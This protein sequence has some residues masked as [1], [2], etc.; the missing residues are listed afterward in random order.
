LTEN[1]LVTL[2]R[3]L[4]GVILT[5]GNLAHQ[6]LGQ[7]LIMNTNEVAMA[8]AAAVIDATTGQ[9]NAAAQIA[10]RTAAPALAARIMLNKQERRV[11][12]KLELLADRERALAR[13]R[14][15]LRR[16]RRKLGEDKA[17]ATV[18]GGG[19]PAGSESGTPAVSP[20]LPPAPATPTPAAPPAAR[21]VAGAR[22]KG[23]ATAKRPAG[24]KRRSRKATKKR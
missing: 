4:G 18:P 20:A 13:R 24:A 23:P 1:P 10:L 5:Q 15:R 3:V 19:A 12:R 2:A 17:R 8:G 9:R 22:K 6:V 11:E 7:I 16:E 21:K 14:T